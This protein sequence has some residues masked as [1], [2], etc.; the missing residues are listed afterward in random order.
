[1]SRPE[2][3]QPRPGSCRGALLAGDQ[4]DWVT[5][6]GPRSGASMPLRKSK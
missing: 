1:M 5:R 2:R 6:T 3:P 4:P